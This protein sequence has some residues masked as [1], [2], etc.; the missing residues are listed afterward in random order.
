MMF[1]SN[2]H[3]SHCLVTYFLALALADEAL[4]GVCQASDLSKITIEPE[5]ICKTISIRKDKAH[6]PVFRAILNG[7]V[8]E[9]R[10]LTAQMFTATLRS[11]GQRAGYKDD[12]T[13]YCFRRAVGNKL[14]GRCNCLS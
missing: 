10:I 5:R 4:V 9:D 14:D 6:K 13:S 3:R 8:S 1:E 11:L 7:K 12:L 2:T